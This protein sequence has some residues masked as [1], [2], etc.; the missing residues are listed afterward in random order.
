[1]LF[2]IEQVEPTNMDKDLLQSIPI[3]ST[4][5]VISKDQYLVGTGTRYRCLT[6]EETSR[7]LARVLSGLSRGGYQFGGGLGSGTV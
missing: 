5:L 7:K 6:S 1:M 2:L 4:L 3:C